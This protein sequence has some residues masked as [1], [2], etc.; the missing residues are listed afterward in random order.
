MQIRS[1]LTLQFIIVVSLIIL[2]GFA[3]VYYSSASYRENE[4][5]RRLENKAQ[6]SAEIFVSVEQIDS[7]MLRIFDKTQ[8]DKLPNENI[9]IYNEENRE[10]YTNNDSLSVDAS[11][12]LLSEIRERGRKKF[13]EEKFEV[14][15]ITYNDNHNRFVVFASAV[16]EYGM[17]KLKNL[18]N[19]LIT[20]AFVIVSIVAL[21]GWIYSGRALRPLN[22][23]IGEVKSL[24]VERLDTRLKQSKNKD[25]IGQLIDTFNSM[26]KRIEEA[27]N[28]QK[29]FV[30]G[31]SHE[32]KNPLTSIT[33][34]LQVVLLNERSSEEYKAI[35]T[36]ILED[37]KQLNRSTLDL[38]E[39][40]RL[41]YENKIILSNVRLDDILW[42]CKDFF[43][44][45][46]PEYKVNISFV[47][48]PE[49]E[50]KL[51]VKGN[52]ALLR[53]TFIN[54]IDNA[55]KFSANKTCYITLSSEPKVLLL[56]FADKGIGLDAK[57]IELIFEPFYRSNSTA[58]VQGHGLGL[59]LTRKII[60]LHSAELHV[61]SESGKGTTFSI[62]FRSEF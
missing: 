11:T 51:I 57:E 37:I 60:Q 33:S 40:A 24:S 17:S 26:L 58:Q 54:L 23:V 35:I 39:Y 12:E 19:T 20:L 13:T 18:R 27:F 16:D 52:E 28:L 2:S 53:I 42:Y 56:D 36:S 3:V 5:Y 10:I 29:L 14:L 31:A 22:D 30:T 47:N 1:R 43:N 48:M 21:A 7:T 41:S 46:N 59:A 62:N 34:Q 4:M 49:D 6:T 15:G 38:I 25:E 9:S 45:T 8:K 32:L 44:K 55:C 61:K 50:N